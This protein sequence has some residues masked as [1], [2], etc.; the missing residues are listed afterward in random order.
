MI[1]VIYDPV[2]QTLYHAV[3]GAGAFRNGKHWRLAETQVKK[4]S[5]LFFISDRSFIKHPQYSEVL[6]QLEK[7]AK[8]VGFSGVEVIQQGGGAMNACWV[9][10]KSPACYFK[11]PCE[12]PGGGALW[13]FSA[14]ACLFNEIN[15]VVSDFRG[16][17]LELNR[18]DSTFMNHRGV[19][20]THD[21]V[22]A[23]LIIGLYEGVKT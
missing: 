10:E 3:K 6:T 9:I 11:F 14:S 8:T 12:R 13:D 19:I 21:D 5:S 15:A 17:P 4:T 20:Y 22:L 16:Q 18:P 1:G 23:K 7:I 2:K